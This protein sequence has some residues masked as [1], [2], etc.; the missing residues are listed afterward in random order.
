MCTGR[1]DSGAGLAA[2]ACAD[3]TPLGTHVIRL[4]RMPIIVTETTDREA[5]DEWV[6]AH[7]GHPLQ[8]W[9]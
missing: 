2:A 1:T 7:G 9:G 3:S 6:L 8:L 4:G 5:W